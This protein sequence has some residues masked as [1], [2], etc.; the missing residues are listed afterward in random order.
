[1]G[2]DTPLENFGA[3]MD[4]DLQEI[5]QS[6]I[7]TSL[8]AHPT[9]RQ[10]KD[11]TVT[12]FTLPRY[13]LASFFLGCFYF[14]TTAVALAELNQAPAGFT[15]LFDGKTLDGWKGRPHLDP[16]AEAGWD[17]ATRK[18][19]NEKF[20]A[21]RKAHWSVDTDKGEIVSDGH[22]VFL[23]TTKD[24]GDFEMYVD[25]KLMQNNGDSGIYLRGCP[26]IQIWDPSN[27]EQIS[28]GIQKGSGALW[29]NNDDNPGKW[30][31]VK[32]DNAIGQWNTFRV[33]MIGSRVWVWFNDQLTVDGQIMDNYYDRSVPIFPTGCIQLQTHGSETRFRN[34][35]I[36]EIDAAEANEILAA[37][38]NGGFQSIFDGK[39]LA[40]WKGPIDQNK[41]ED[42][43][44]LSNHGTIFTEKEYGDFSVQFEFLLP[45]G[46]NNG[47]AIRY[48]GEGDTAYVGMCELQ[49]LDNVAS[50][51]A[52][53]DDRQYHGSA[54][55]MIAAH[56][57]FLRP[58]GTW[59]H[60]RVTVQGSR[61]QVELNGNIILDGDL[62][63]VTEYMANS[64][65]PGKDRKSGHFGFA[66]HGDPVRYRNVSLKEL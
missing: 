37:R 23:T 41:I 29:N 50:Q 51:Y 16:R 12:R 7:P 10:T 22:G 60:Q 65:H 42:G 48:P 35:F 20:E 1:L 5:S 25:W 46:G 27:K 61:I 31:L 64:P 44:I 3:M 33:R 11:Y 49:V 13:G 4:S 57:G 19:E 55:G 38:D 9:Y 6:S 56:R 59:N 63:K 40:G 14:L 58:A 8:D 2:A 17:D 43:V 30:P 28:L 34:V 47:L 36:R 66:G 24:Y 62:S 39:S 26:Q 15:S 52:K 54:Y 21:D 45:P 32:A 18:S 53:L